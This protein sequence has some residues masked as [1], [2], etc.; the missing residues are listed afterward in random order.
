MSNLVMWTALVGTLM[1]VLIA[2]VNRTTWSSGTK[3]TV[4]LVSSAVAGIATA[5]LNGE[6]AGRDVIAAVL[7]AATATTVA[8]HAW[9]KPTGIAPALEE[10][11][12]PTPRGYATR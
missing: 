3:A 9:W 4:A 10:A 11:T 2:F 8:Y 7:V 5:W 12:S 6:L 1:P